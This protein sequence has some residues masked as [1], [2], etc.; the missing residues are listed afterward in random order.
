MKATEIVKMGGARMKIDGEDCMLIIKDD[1]TSVDIFKVHDDGDTLVKL[2]LSAEDKES[3][4][5]KIP[6]TSS[7][8]CSYKMKLNTVKD[9]ISV[10][11]KNLSHI[12]VNE[13]ECKPNEQSF[14][15]IINLLFLLLFT[16]YFFSLLNVNLAYSMI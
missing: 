4:E 5:T 2:E 11:K 7:K 9:S 15:N 12:K 6:S 8:M 10:N 13:N 16:A 1:M 3:I 14:K